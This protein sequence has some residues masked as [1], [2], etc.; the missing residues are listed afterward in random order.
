MNDPRRGLS[1]V[2]GHVS[3]VTLAAFSLVEILIVV[4]LLS[5]I[6]LGLVAM[7]GQTQRAFRTGMTQTDVLEGG[8]M[9]TD[10]IAREM[11]QMTPAYLSPAG[12]LPNNT[13]AIQPNFYVWL[14]GYTP[15][16]QPLPGSSLPRVN[17]ME[18]L[19]FLYRRNQEW[20]GVGYF[21]RSS[22]PAT[23][24]LKPPLVQAGSPPPATVGV[25]TLYHFETNAP[26]LS[27]RTPADLFN[28]FLVAA[29]GSETNAQR[30]M[31][32]VIHFRVRAHNTNGFWIVSDRDVSASGTQTNTDIR[33]STVAPGEVGLYAFYSNAV[34]AAVELE[35]GILEDRAWERFKSLPDAASQY[36]YITDQAGRVHLFRL[37]VP[38]R[39]VD[40]LAY[41]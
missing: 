38:I 35:L 29:Q 21:V 11:E 20:I 18:D 24:F 41:R 28:A 13:T 17:L 36:R 2:T 14:P 23:R 26:A 5:V 27:G 10:L 3:R 39:N 4:G 8:R 25:G 19:F 12:P 22:D 15:L 31:D 37:R 33:A 30:I 9:A 34:P 7:F 32:G 6:I 1:L 40:P 16:V